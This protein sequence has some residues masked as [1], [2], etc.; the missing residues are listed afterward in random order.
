MPF[1]MVIFL[2]GTLAKMNNIAGMAAKFLPNYN[3]QVLPGRIFTNEPLN[4]NFAYN[5]LV[6]LLW[7]IIGAGIFVYA[8]KKKTDS[9]ISLFLIVT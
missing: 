6:I 9:I 8:Y 3:M 7:I 1:F 5:I 4:I 2:A